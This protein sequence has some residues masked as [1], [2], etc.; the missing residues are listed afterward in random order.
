MMNTKNR[1]DNNGQK[2]MYHVHC[3]NQYIYNWILEKH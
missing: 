2:K 1:N 3:Q